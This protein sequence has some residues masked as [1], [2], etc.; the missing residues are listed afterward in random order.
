MKSMGKQN[1]SDENN[2]V[3]SEA[4]E[5]PDMIGNISKPDP[6]K[7]IP[8]CAVQENNNQMSFA[9][10]PQR[11]NFFYQKTFCDVASHIWQV[12]CQNENRTVFIEMKQ[13]NLCSVLKDFEEFFGNSS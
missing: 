11:E 4:L 5:S 12:T 2:V 3:M 7:C 10:Y 8:A 13:P 9:P 6:I 1:I